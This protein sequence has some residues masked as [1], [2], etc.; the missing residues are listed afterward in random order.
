ME[1]VCTTT[2]PSRLGT[3][4]FTTLVYP[5]RDLDEQMHF[6]YFRMST[7]RFDELLRHVQPLRPEKATVSQMNANYVLS[8]PIT[9]LMD[10]VGV[11]VDE[12]TTLYI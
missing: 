2:K 3:G 6:R 7:G 1:V 8:R 4:E 5:L 12:I 11:Q 9:A 10:G